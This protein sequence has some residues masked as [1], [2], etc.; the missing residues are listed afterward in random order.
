MT[1][2]MR[3]SDSGVRPDGSDARTDDDAARWTT[4]SG[5]DSVSGVNW[6]GLQELRLINCQPP[7]P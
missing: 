4:H 3:P 7:R 5:P 2:G 1:G 6:D